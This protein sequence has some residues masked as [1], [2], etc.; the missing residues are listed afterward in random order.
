MLLNWLA[1]AALLSDPVSGSRHL[2]DVRRYAQDGWTLTI[3]EDTFS[4]VTTC[5]LVGRHMRFQSGAIGFD[6]RTT[7]GIDEDWYAIDGASPRPWRDVYPDLLAAGVRLETGGI[8]NPTDGIVWLPTEA[9]SSAHSVRVEASTSSGR[10]LRVFRLG[11]FALM[12]A[13]AL[14]LGC[15]TNGFVA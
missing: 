6:T 3:S 7:E 11:G 14:R 13:A 1:A 12:H 5:S 9:V 15:A 4:R 10:R 2:L 8:D